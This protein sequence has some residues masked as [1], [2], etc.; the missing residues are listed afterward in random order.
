MI[1][2]LS[3][4]EDAWNAEPFLYFQ[5]ENTPMSKEIKDIHFET[6]NALITDVVSRT[7]APEKKALLDW[8][9]GL[10]EIRENSDGRFVKAKSALA[11]TREAKIV[12]PIVKIIAKKSKQYT[13]DDRSLSARMALGAGG[14][15]S[16]AFA[17]KGAGIAALGTAIGVPLWVV[18][19]GGGLLAGKLIEELKDAL[20]KTNA[21]DANYII[22]DA[23]KTDK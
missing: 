15:A 22:I 6:Q 7:S 11:I 12:W 2:Q 19:A 4:I 8:L 10:L 20:N 23:K 18:F 1:K 21:G 17:G 9:T 5:K 14:I 13:W 16:I 3:T